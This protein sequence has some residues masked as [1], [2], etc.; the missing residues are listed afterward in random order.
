MKAS[1]QQLKLQDD[2]NDGYQ[3]IMRKAKHYRLSSY[4]G[5][6]LRSPSTPSLDV[7]TPSPCTTWP[8]PSGCRCRY[9][10]NVRMASSTCK[11]SEGYAGLDKTPAG[12]M[13]ST[14]LEPGFPPDAGGAGLDDMGEIGGVE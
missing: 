4:A 13:E 11:V 1:N 14:R 8:S 7:D 9:V 10:C 5:G 3:W 2:L 6:G 12:G